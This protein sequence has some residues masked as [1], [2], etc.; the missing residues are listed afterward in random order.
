MY[1][2]SLKDVSIINIYKI[3]IYTLRQIQYFKN[4][5]WLNELVLNESFPTLTL[6][7]L[8]PSLIIAQ[9]QVFPQNWFCDKLSQ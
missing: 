7:K 1:K 3:I 2:V 4:T 5:I 9:N 6:K 8:R